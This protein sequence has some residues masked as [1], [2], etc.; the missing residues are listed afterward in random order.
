VIAVTLL[1][2]ITEPEPIAQSR[3]DIAQIVADLT[4][5]GMEVT[6]EIAKC[7]QVNAYYQPK[8]KHLVVCRELVEYSPWLAR[9]AAA[10]E[11][12]HAM[13]RQ[14]DLPITGMEEMAADE[15]AALELC[16]FSDHCM[17]LARTAD[18]F[19]TLDGEELPADPHPSDRRRGITLMRLYL[20]PAPLVHTWGRLLGITGVK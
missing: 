6:W 18:Y 4:F 12:G 3:L 16:I 10:H 15:V 17:D 9:F 19:Y 20:D 7:G 13:V 11:M 8:L 5:P 2:A 14:L 1:L